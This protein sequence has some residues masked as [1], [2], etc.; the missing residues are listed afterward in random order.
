MTAATAFST[1]ITGINGAMRCVS[2]KR[3]RLELLNINSQLIQANSIRNW[4]G[5]TRGWRRRPPS[6]PR[7]LL[8]PYAGFH[9][10]HFCCC[11]ALAFSPSRLPPPSKAAA[12]AQIKN[13]DHYISKHL[14]L[15]IYEV[16]LVLLWGEPEPCRCSVSGLLSESVLDNWLI[17]VKSDTGTHGPHPR[18]EEISFTWVRSKG[19]Y[20]AEYTQETPLILISTHHRCL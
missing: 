13:A 17:K 12:R 9:P 10:T 11:W 8:I 3:T 1:F 14:W 16:V 18:Y 5:V 7:T 19:T 15:W 6:V 4:A 20:V 2:E